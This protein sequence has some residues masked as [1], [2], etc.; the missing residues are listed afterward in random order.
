MFIDQTGKG[1]V[2]VNSSV[3][4][5]NGIGDVFGVAREA[6]TKA[7]VIEYRKAAQAKRPWQ[8]VLDRAI[9]DANK[10]LIPS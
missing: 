4:I 10:G 7:K 1:A 9:I 6:N 3:T 5:V 8:N 2:T